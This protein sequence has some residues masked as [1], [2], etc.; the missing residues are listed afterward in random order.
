MQR[1]D[2]CLTVTELCLYS[3]VM[4]CDCYR[5]VCVQR[6]GWCVIVTELCLYSSVTGV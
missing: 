6:Y 3:D 4:V 5:A 2:W 1:C